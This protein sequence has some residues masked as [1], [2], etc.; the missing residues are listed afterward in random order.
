MH[1]FSV[2]VY[3]CLITV[4]I[5]CTACEPAKMNMDKIE[6]TV[7]RIVNGDTW[8]LDSEPER[9]RAWGYNTPECHPDCS[10]DP[11]TVFLSDIIL[12]EK[13]I[14][15]WI[16]QKVSFD[17]KV[18]RCALSDGRDIGQIMISNNMAVEDCRFSKGFYKTC[19]N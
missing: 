11:S 4:F 9:V 14:C 19:S 13:L 10:E 5:F 18:V 8:Y 3:A 2:K 7:T 1:I 17:R 15:D 12:N 16:D 6:G